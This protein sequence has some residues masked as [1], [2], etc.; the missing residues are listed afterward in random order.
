M[1]NSQ[2]NKL[3]LGIINSAKVTWN[4]SSNMICDTNKDISFPHKL[5]LTDTQILR[6]QKAFAKGLK[7]SKNW[8]V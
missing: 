7:I 4:L 1:F 3:K 5:L 2:L 6:L 8:S